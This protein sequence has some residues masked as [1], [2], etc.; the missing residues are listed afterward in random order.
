VKRQ[1]RVGQPFEGFREYEHLMAW[2]IGRNL[3]DVVEPGPRRSANRIMLDV[4][5][6]IKQGL[7]LRCSLYLVE[8]G[9]NDLVT[10]LVEPMQPASF[11]L[12]TGPG[13]WILAIVGGSR[14]LRTG[15]IV[16]TVSQKDVQA[17]A[18]GPAARAG[19]D[20]SSV[21]KE[22]GR[23]KRRE[24]HPFSTPPSSKQG[25]SLP[26]P[27]WSSGKVCHHRQS[28]GKGGISTE[29]VAWQRVLTPLSPLPYHGRSQAYRENPGDMCGSTGHSGSCAHLKE[30]EGLQA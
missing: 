13:P 3:L 21:E 11:S 22:S 7:N 26:K 25:S 19:E 20:V 15:T 9:R 17:G 6:I 27:A 29:L 14:N 30:N 8:S 24:K 4:T 16:I 2:G 18:K 10:R 12:M 28:K 1:V 5:E 23:E